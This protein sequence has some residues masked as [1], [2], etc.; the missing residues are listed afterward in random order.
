MDLN[1]LAARI[2][3]ESTDPEARDDGK[4]REAVERG[5]R[6][7]QRGG[8][9]RAERMRARAAERSRSTGGTG[10]L[11]QSARAGQPRSVLDTLRLGPNPRRAANL[12]GIVGN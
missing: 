3:K 5:R 9:V 11:E 12:R 10:A 6:G 7:G 1:R 2:V 8:R 4:N